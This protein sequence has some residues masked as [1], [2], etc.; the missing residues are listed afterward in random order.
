M[1]HSLN[2]GL[3]KVDGTHKNE[4]G[5]LVSVGLGVPFILDHGSRQQRRKNE[6]S[7]H[8][9]RET[10]MRDGKAFSPILPFLSLSFVHSASRKLSMVLILSPYVCFC[11]SQSDFSK[12]QIFVSRSSF[13][14]LPP[15]PPCGTRRSISSN[16]DFSCACP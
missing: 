9:K 4:I 14:L 1:L 2:G 5:M 15:F 7:V 3:E 6:T 11:M 13:A 16:L 8:K 12:I 10:A